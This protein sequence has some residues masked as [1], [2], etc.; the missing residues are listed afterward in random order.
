MKNIILLDPHSAVNDFFAAGDV[1]ASAPATA[2]QDPR[3]PKLHQAQNHA[4]TYITTHVELPYR[5]QSPHYQ[6]F[7]LEVVVETVLRYP[8][9]YISEKT[10]RPIANGRMFVV[11][12][13]AGTLDLLR[14]KGFETFGD[15]ID[16]SYDQEPDA[17][18]RLRSAVQQV[19]AFCSRSMSD[20]RDCVRR[21][22]PR[23]Q[24]NFELLQ[25]LP[26]IEAIALA[27]KLQ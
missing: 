3:L 27:E 22:Q 5:Y 6:K 10:M 18:T 12:G 15:V 17:V 9:A 11:V 8:Y 25:K 13:A 19:R 7:A 16:E 23:L 26:E 1:D 21:V 14:Q 24:H 2:K 4:N 20:V